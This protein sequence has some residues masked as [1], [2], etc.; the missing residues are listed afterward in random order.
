MEDLVA[1]TA[2][3]GTVGAVVAGY[4]QWRIDRS[5]SATT[6]RIW[7]EMNESYM[8]REVL[9]LRFQ[10]MSEHLDRV[11]KHLDRVDQHLTNVAKHLDQVNSPVIV[12]RIQAISLRLNII[13]K[14][15]EKLETAG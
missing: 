12:D 7:G 9:E 8:G 5:V 1:L 15:L 14:K 6:T 4:L 10:Q 11:D 3:V 2:V 13:D